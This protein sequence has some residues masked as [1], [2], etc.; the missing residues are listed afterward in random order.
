MSIILEDSGNALDIVIDN[1]DKKGLILDRQVFESLTIIESVDSFL[2]YGQLLL[3][4]A[5]SEDI[6][7]VI[8]SGDDVYVRVS[9]SNETEMLFEIAG[10]SSSPNQ[11]VIIELIQNPY[12]LEN[13]YIE[14]YNNILISKIVSDI[15]TNTKSYKAR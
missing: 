4:P 1:G 12:P 8:R 13:L 9:G 7:E 5:F 6:K 2:L 14:G 10:V 11:Q 3:Q 15:I